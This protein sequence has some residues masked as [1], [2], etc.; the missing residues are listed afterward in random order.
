VDLNPILLLAL[1]IGVACG[2]RPVLALAIFDW[3]LAFQGT[4]LPGTANSI[5]THPFTPWALMIGALVEFV[6]DR[7]MPADDRG[8]PVQFGFRIVTSA[9]A[10]GAFVVPS[11]SL[12]MGAVSGM[13]GGAIGCFGGIQLRK[14]LARKLRSD[15]TAALVEYVIVVLIVALAFDGI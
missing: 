3:Q 14:A 1:T 9:L 6:F 5:L 4:Y 11:A 8:K 7:R 13:I 15:R 12:T 2:I 10:G